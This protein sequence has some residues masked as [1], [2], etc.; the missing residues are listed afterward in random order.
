[1]QRAVF[2]VL[3]TLSLLSLPALAKRITGGFKVAKLHLLFPN[4]KEWDVAYDPA[5]TP[6]L[7]QSY[8][9]LGKGAQSYVFESE[10]GRYVVKLFRYDQPSVEEKVVDLFNAAKLAYEEMREETGLLF[11]HLNLSEG[12]LPVLQCKDNLGRSYKF[13]LD[14]IRFALQK[15]ALGWSETL[16][17]LDNLEKRIDQFFSLL[18]ARTDRKIYNADPSLSRNF[19]FLE[20]RAIEFDFG[21]Y[22]KRETLESK[23][24]IERFASKFR[25]WLVQN[26]PSQLAYFDRKMGEL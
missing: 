13:P 20:D 11:V 26:D 15:K 8:S 18:K 9:F 25:K 5:L 21:N 2:L 17:Q 7:S 12:I 16:Q 23:K 24:E 4:R 6:I 1:M 10:D 3:F 22:R 19:G 14:K